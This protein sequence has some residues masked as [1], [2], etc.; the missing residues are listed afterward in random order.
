MVS[1]ACRVR[2]A[3]LGAGRGAGAVVR[4]E[5]RPRRAAFARKRWCSRACEWAGSVAVLG[6]TKNVLA[7]SGCGF[8]IYYTGNENQ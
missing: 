2:A 4:G 3:G 8:W 5:S 7:Q 1:E 6:K